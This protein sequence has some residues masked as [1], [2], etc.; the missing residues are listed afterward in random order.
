MKMKKRKGQ[1]PCRMYGPKRADYVSAFTVSTVVV[2]ERKTGFF[3]SEEGPLFGNR[4]EIRITF[5][6]FHM[7]FSESIA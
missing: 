1:S 5:K 4:W 2:G 7:L 3:F 6:I